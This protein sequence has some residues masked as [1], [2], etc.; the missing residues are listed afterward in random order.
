[1]SCPFVPIDVESC[2]EE[3]L[4][5]DLEVSAELHPTSAKQHNVNKTSLFG[6]YYPM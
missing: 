1:M 2:S 4:T 5:G 6:K 3:E